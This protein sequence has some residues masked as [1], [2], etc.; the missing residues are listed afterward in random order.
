MASDEIKVCGVAACRTLF[1]VRPDDIVRVYVTK[2]V[3]RRFSALVAYCS[4][5][6]LAYHVVDEEELSK[7]AATTHHEGVCVLART[8]APSLTDLLARV[9]DGPALVVALDGVDNPHNLGAILR[10]AA[11]FGVLALV[12]A[13]Q[14]GRTAPSAHRVAEGGAE[15]VPVVRVE[16]FVEALKRLSASGFEIVATAGDGDR[17]LYDHRFTRRTVLVMGAEREGVS[18]PV[19]GVADAV[20][21]I[22]GTGAVESLNVSVATAVVIAERWRQTQR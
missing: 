12:R 6:R 11:H 3:K 2:A 22:G 18:R 7:V 5:E 8:W 17:D 14:D 15:V 13:E 4:R 9:G 16:D 21:S 20:L 1:E 19:R 10:S